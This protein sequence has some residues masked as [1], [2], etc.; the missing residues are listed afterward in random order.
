MQQPTY[1]AASNSYRLPQ[2]AASGPDRTEAID[3]ARRLR[4]LARR[5]ADTS[6]GSE[7]LEHDFDLVI[8]A[9]GR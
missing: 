9:L 1:D 2:D 3:A 4:E 7:A 5:A 8:A 6:A